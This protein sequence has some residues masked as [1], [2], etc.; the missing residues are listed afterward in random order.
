MRFSHKQ[1]YGKDFFYPANVKA[2]MFVE[3]FPHSSGK[4]KSLTLE[5]IRIMKEIGITFIIKE[6]FNHKK[7]GE[8]NADP[9]NKRLQ[10]VS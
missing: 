5:Q 10:S 9:R 1:H 7:Q 6:S 8:S 3:A 2:K 4:R